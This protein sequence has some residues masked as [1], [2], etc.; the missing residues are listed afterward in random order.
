MSPRFILKSYIFATIASLC[1]FLK[2]RIDPRRL[3]ETYNF[4]FKFLRRTYDDPIK[5]QDAP[6]VMSEFLNPYHQ[7]GNNPDDVLRRVQ[8]VFLALT[9]QHDRTYSACSIEQR[10]YAGGRYKG[11]LSGRQQR[12]GAGCE[13]R[14]NGDEYWG[15]WLTHTTGF[16]KMTIQGQT[17]YGSWN[18]EGY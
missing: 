5:N 6:F 15:C 16:G 12:A 9:F 17:S 7:H 13:R 3:Q 4:L 11:E 1:D 2:P 14:H 8:N 18:I 10:E